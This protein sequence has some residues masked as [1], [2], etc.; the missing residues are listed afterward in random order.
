[1]KKLILF[2]ALI[3]GVVSY[4][5]G[6]ENK[7]GYNI[8]TSTN[9]GTFVHQVE[10]SN[11]VSVNS[12]NS[13][14][15]NKLTNFMVVNDTTV[16]QVETNRQGIISANN[17][18]MS[19]MTTMTAVFRATSTILNNRVT[20][21]ENAAP[22]GGAGMT[23]F[24]AMLSCGGDVFKTTNFNDIPES[25]IPVTVTWNITGVYAYNNIVSTGS[26]FYAVG[27]TTDNV[28]N[29]FSNIITGIV[30]SSNVKVSGWID[31]AT[32][33]VTAGQ[34]LSMQVIQTD[35]VSFPSLATIMVRYWRTE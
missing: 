12:S 21:L 8:V 32:Q 15:I 4:S 6:I 19:T 30:V 16:V 28:V 33:I 1:M 14:Q 31:T 10:Y 34:Q 24:Y 17:L 22:A 5:F 13:A 29:V 25:I 27:K 26:T 18:I 7:Q 20:I 11:Y 3:T 9:H 23:T 35:A 2:L